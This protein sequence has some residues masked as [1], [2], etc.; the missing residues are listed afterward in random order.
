M[1]ETK[2]TQKLFEDLYEGEPWI[3]VTLFDT[4]KRIPAEKAAKKIAP[5]WNSIWEITNH[6]ITW[7]LNVLERLH[8]NKMTTPDNNY[9]ESVTDTSK[10]AWKKTLKHL[11]E[12]QQQWTSFLK[13]FNEKDFE[14]IYSR[15]GLSY[16]EHIHGIIQHDA[17]HLGQIVLLAKDV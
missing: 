6:I 12:S 16:Y 17:Y 14:N 11:E 4:L 15:N 2:R 1:K 7:R 10:A 5:H 8:G 13:I 3:G 9:F